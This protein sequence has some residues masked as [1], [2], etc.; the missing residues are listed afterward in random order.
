MALI[1]VHTSRLPTSEMQVVL[2]RLPE[3]WVDDGL[4]CFPDSI[5]GWDIATAGTIHDARYC[6]RLWDPGD[7]D[8]GW[9]EAADSELGRNVR[10]LLPFGLRLVGFGV[11]LAV[12]EV[13][14]MKAFDSCGRDPYGASMAQL[15]LGQCRHGVP[16]PDWMRKGAA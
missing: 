13:G 5:F 15:R 9:R 12:Y 7:L 11:F 3:T 1:P 6:T 16:V 8:R 10:A 4:S 14:G 2:D